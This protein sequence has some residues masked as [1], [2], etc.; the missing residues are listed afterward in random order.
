MIPQPGEARTTP[1]VALRTVKPVP[2]FNPLAKSGQIT[3]SIPANDTGDARRPN[4]LGKRR[5]RQARLRAR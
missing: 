1:R 5:R 3:A 2:P 4:I